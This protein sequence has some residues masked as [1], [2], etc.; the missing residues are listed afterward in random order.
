LVVVGMTATPFS[1]G[2]PDDAGTLAVV[3]FDTAAPELISC[4]AAGEL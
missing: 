4:F 2:D 3:G 1:I